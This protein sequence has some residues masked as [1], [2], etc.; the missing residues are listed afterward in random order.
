MVIVAP[1]TRTGPQGV[2][3]VSSG[4]GTWEP[5]SGRGIHFTVVQLLSDVNGTYTGS[6]TIDGHPTVSEDDRTF[7]DDSPDSGPTIRDAAGHVL[8]APRGHPP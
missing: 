1:P 3:F 6:V 4:V 2:S 5:T 8:A 7:V